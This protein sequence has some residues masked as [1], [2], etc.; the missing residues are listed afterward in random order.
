MIHVDHFIK[1][2]MLFSDILKAQSIT[3]VKL[4]LPHHFFSILAPFCLVGDEAPHSPMTFWSCTCKLR[5]NICL[6]DFIDNGIAK[7]SHNFK[8]LRF[9]GIQRE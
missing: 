3:E 2:N 9:P 6:I 5:I 4:Y 7:F 1:R 8:D